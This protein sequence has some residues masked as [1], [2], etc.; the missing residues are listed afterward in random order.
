[1]QFGRLILVG[2]ASTALAACQRE[3]AAVTNVE[4]NLMVSGPQE[5]VERFVR[6]Q[7][8]L[9]PALKTWPISDLPGGRTQ[10]IVTIP[11]DYTAEQVA[12]TTR[13]AIAAGLTWWFPDIRPEEAAMLRPTTDLFE[14]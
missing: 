9:S 4:R 7:E 3:P 14:S 2:L 11:A 12:H 10:A 5:D 6:L 8:A 1:M 13:E